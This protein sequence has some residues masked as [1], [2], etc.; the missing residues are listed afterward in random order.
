MWMNCEMK[1]NWCKTNSKHW[2]TC[3]SCDHRWC[4]ECHKLIVS[5]GEYLQY[6]PEISGRIKYKCPFCKYEYMSGCKYLSPKKTNTKCSI[7]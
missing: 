3:A 7:C 4:S 5:N 6:P 1:C 2:Y